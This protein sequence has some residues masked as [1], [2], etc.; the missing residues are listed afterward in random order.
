MNLIVAVSKD[1][2]IGCE[3]NLLFR[4]PE[5][6]KYFRKTTIGKVVVMGHN[7][8]KSLPNGKPLKDRVNIVLSK[9]RELTIDD[10]IVCNSTAELFETLKAYPPNDIFIIGGAAVYSEFFNH[11]KKA[12]ITKI[13]AV[14]PA[15]T[16]FSNIDEM[17][18]WKLI[19]E[20][21]AKEHDGLKYKFCVYENLM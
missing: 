18:N 1:W 9:N 8:F 6:Q 21:E 3:N 7:T 10:V 20:S 16:F 12:Y 5:D 4:I 13:D 19:Q 11:C 2:G 17:D 15:D 14:L